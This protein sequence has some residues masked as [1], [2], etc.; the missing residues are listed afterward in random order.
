MG[1]WDHCGFMGEASSV[2]KRLGMGILLGVVA[3]GL[4]VAGTELGRRTVKRLGVDVGAQSIVDIL[5]G[6][7]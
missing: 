5:S 4:L 6:L 3:L 1:I 7:F 2:N